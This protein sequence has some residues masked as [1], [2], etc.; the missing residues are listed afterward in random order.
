MKYFFVT[1]FLMTSL[2][3]IAAP[4]VDRY[5]QYIGE[6]WPG[7]I[8]C[9]AQ[10]KADLEQEEQE[11]ANC[12]PEL[13]RFDRF[14]GVKGEFSSRATGFFRVA[15]LQGRW[16]L[17]SPEGNPFFL[18]GVDAIPYSEH[19]YFTK[20]R[21]KDGSLRRVFSEIPP[22]PEQ[23]PEAWR[24]S[25]SQFSF[26]AANIRRKYGPNFHDRWMDVTAKRLRAWGFNASG[27]WNNPF[28]FDRLPFLVDKRLTLKRIGRY[29][30]P[31][32]PDFV[33]AM[34]AQIAPHCARYRGNPLLIG[35]QFENEDGWN[36]TTIELLLKDRSGTLAAKRAFLDQLTKIH[37]PDIGGM[38]DLPGCSLEDLLKVPL[39]A[40]KVP[41]PFSS[42]FIRKSARRYYSVLRKTVRKYD[43][44]HLLLGPSHCP[45]QSLE[46][47][48]ESRNFID[49]IPLHEYNLNS[50]WI[51][52]TLAEHL[53]KWDKPYAV[54]EFSFTNHRRG[55]SAYTPNGTVATEAD[56]G[57]AFQQFTEYHAANPLCVGYSWFIMCDQP[58]T[59]RWSDPEAHNFG[60]VDVTDRP[61]RKMLQF[62]KSANDRVFRVHSGKTAPVKRQLLL[63][64]FQQIKDFMSDSIGRFDFDCAHPALHNNRIYRINFQTRQE[65][66]VPLRIGTIDAG[67][68][69]NFKKLEF[70]VFLWKL[71]RNQKLQEWFLIEESSDNLHFTPAKAVFRLYR[72]NTFNEYV[73]TPER[74]KDDTRFVRLNFILR[75]S[76]HPWAVSLAKVHVE[77]WTSLNEDDAST[78]R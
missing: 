41:K 62:V 33:P 30:D 43:P 4:K 2:Y 29:I 32:D 53:K 55:F 64:G 60:L 40:A 67:K 17:I 10:L 22:D 27:K 44:D 20:T 77:R 14:G 65:T 57:R 76:A 74:L 48:E 34:E 18:R 25:G 50:R 75:D 70:Y 1:L 24:A 13:A 36:F 19:G 52:G 9:D 47:I 58:V 12:L 56:R 63:A 38:F 23:F 11:L 61:Y 49:I 37:G 42:D 6:D 46:W 39:D 66:G 59:G 5:G 21:D 7:K 51:G 8:I 3:L 45:L 73:M 69:G 31:Y 35:Y 68:S 26:R 16:W 78:C 28:V 54:L 15:K 72:E 71:T